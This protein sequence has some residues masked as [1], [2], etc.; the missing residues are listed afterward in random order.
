MKDGTPSST[1][2][3]IGRNGTNLHWWVGPVSSGHINF[4]LLDSDGVYKGTKGTSTVT[5]D[6]WHHI[7][8]VRDES[9]NENRIYV[10][11]VKENWVTYDYQGDF[12]GDGELDIGHLDFVYRYQGIVDEVAIY[13]RALTDAEIQ[14]HHQDGL[15]E[16][17]YCESPPLEFGDAPEGALAYPS[18]GMPGSFPTCINCG[19]VGWIQHN[20]SFGAFFGPTFDFELDGN[21]GNCPTFPP[22]DADECFADDDAGL[23]FPEPFTIQGPVDFETVVPCPSH[24]GAPLGMACQT[25]VW[26]VDVDI[27][28]HMPGSTDGYVNV[29]IDWNRDGQW[30]G[31]SMCPGGSAPE[32]VLVDFPVSNG[33]SGPLSGLSPSPFTIGPNPGYVWARFTISER[34]VGADWNGEGDFEDGETEDYLLLIPGDANGDGS[35]DILDVTKVEMMILGLAAETPGADANCDGNVNILDVTQIEL[36]IMGAG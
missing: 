35:V 25:A 36:I 17:G 20:N 6:E 22:Y 14:Q 29:L 12:K 4:G 18:T 33:Y 28:I 5:N 8:A 19:P 7:V 31:S 30:G 13:D 2:V 24:T 32:H 11:G 15:A 26:G 3:I 21:A 23:M 16:L 1:E 27:E 10:D 9:T 34:P